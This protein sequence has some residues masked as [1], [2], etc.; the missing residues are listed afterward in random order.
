MLA[1]ALP[2]DSRPACATPEGLRLVD[3]AF[4][5]IG[6]PES[7]ELRDR[8]CPTCPVRLLCFVLGNTNG[9]HGVWGG[10]TTNERV[11]AG[12]RPSRKNGTPLNLA[13]IHRRG[14]D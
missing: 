9:E 8:F 7:H 3:A 6:G 12:G 4:D 5:H 11:R 2:A 14:G 13:G 1:L 10:L